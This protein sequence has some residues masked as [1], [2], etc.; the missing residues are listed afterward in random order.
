MIPVLFGNLFI[1][2]FFICIFR[3]APFLLEWWR[4][5]FSLG[6]IKQ[7][8]WSSF[9][10]LTSIVIFTLAG[11]LLSFDQSG[12]KFALPDS[13][14]NSQLE[15]II[16]GPSTGIRPRPNQPQAGIPSGSLPVLPVGVLNDAEINMANFQLK[17][18]IA[19]INR[20][21][22]AY[23]FCSKYFAIF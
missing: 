12:A 20:G 22:K 14:W 23:L 15:N 13:E 7:F 19:A 11:I 6:M 9:D 5:P 2:N 1:N 3:D 17:Y 18:H 10:E 21:R 4:Y 8:E 16:A